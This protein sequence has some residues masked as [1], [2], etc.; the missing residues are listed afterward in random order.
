[1]TYMRQML[2]TYSQAAYGVLEGCCNYRLTFSAERW[3]ATQRR[4]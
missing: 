2:V 3:A 1:M 4:G